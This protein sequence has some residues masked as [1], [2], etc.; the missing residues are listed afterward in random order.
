[1]DAPRY[2]IYF[3]PPPD[4]KLYRFGADFLGYDCYTG[5]E[6]A[7]TESA[8]LRPPEWVALTR[9]PRIYGFHATLKAPFRLQ[10]TVFETD[11]VEELERFAATPRVIPTIEPTVQALGEFIALVPN[12][13]EPSLDRLAADCVTAFDHFRRPLTPEER[14]KRLSGSL[15]GRQIQNLE[16][17]G[18]P[19]VFGEFRFHMTLAGPVERHRRDPIV[20]LLQALLKHRHGSR[21]LPIGRVALVRQPAQAAPFRVL[22][23]AEL[24]APR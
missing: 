17:W 19:Y 24:Q 5:E 13:A 10:P 15:N 9:A 20:T 12:H 11:L 3:I 16:Q 18:Y 23:H 21:P 8:G 22:C 7:Y 1:M 2:A 4:T 6:L 14:H